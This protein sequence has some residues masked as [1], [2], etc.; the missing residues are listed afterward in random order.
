MVTLAISL[1]Q[2]EGAPN[3]PPIYKQPQSADILQATKDLIQRYRTVENDTYLDEASLLL[4]MVDNT[5]SDQTLGN[6]KLRL[7]TYGIDASAY[8][9]YTSNGTDFEAKRITTNFEK[10]NNTNI[11]TSLLTI[12]FYIK[13][14]HRD[15]CFCRPSN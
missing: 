1:I 14:K 4:S 6:T 12:G 5:N 9:I 8:L 13:L 3:F 11:L 15:Q 10:N 7:F 2:H